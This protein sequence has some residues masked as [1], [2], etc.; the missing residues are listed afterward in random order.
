V[1][2]LIATILLLIGLFVSIAFFNFPEESLLVKTTHQ[3]KLNVPIPVKPLVD[4]DVETICLLPTYYNEISD[5]GD[6]NISKINQYLKEQKIYI[7]DVEMG[8]VTINNH[9]IVKVE[10][11]TGTVDHYL[12]FL[13]RNKKAILPNKFVP[14]ECASIDEAY[15]VFLK[16]E[17]TGTLM[18][19]TFK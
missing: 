13:K 3:M 17:E 6:E 1:K 15:L 14:A 4:K 9:N 2:K 5:N 7:D 11:T 8:F 10:K 16:G 18:L 12:E 19:G